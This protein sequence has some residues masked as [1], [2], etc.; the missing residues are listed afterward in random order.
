[1]RKPENLAAA[2]QT[3]EVKKKEK[4]EMRKPENLAA[5]KL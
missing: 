5:A 2:H 4:Q 3:F 1:M